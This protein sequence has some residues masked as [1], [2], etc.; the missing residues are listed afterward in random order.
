MNLTQAT[1]DMLRADGYERIPKWIE[2]DLKIF[3]A[4]RGEMIK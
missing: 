2:R 4:K 3:A 1:A